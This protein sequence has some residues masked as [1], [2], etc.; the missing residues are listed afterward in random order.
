MFALCSPLGKHM[1]GGIKI[2]RKRSRRHFPCGVT[3]AARTAGVG[4]VCAS[5]SLECTEAHAPKAAP[6][7]PAIA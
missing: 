4:I 7:R 1:A 3:G 2:A 6:K 5:T